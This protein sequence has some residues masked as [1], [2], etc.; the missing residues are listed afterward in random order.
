MCRQFNPVPFHHTF[1][2]SQV[3]KATG[4]EP[5]S[6]CS[7]QGARTRIY[8]EKVM[9]RKYNFFSIERKVA[10]TDYIFYESESDQ[11]NRVY[12]PQTKD[13]FNEFIDVLWRLIP[14]KRKTREMQ[15]N[16][17]WIQRYP[18]LFVKNRWDGGIYLTKMN[19][20]E[21]LY[22][23]FDYHEGSDW[24]S[25]IPFEFYQMQEE[26]LQEFLLINPDLIYLYTIIDI[27]E[28]YGTFR[29]YDNGCTDGG[30]KIINKYAKIIEKKLELEF[31]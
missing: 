25:V 8:K 4:F 11:H 3:G 18:W 30:R 5:V 13:D 23:W 29:W 9:K 20:D 24:A 22:D 28:K 1:G 17:S 21:L 31:Y 14:S 26:L 12:V 7:N 27:K 19:S 16:Y 10:G 6:P 2:Y 15:Q